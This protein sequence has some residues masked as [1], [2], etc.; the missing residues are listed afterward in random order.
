MIRLL[1]FSAKVLKG[2][3]REMAGKNVSHKRREKRGPGIKQASKQ[4]TN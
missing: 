3:W 4:A 2:K 1:A